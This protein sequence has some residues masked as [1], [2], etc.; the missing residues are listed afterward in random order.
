MPA[1]EIA[2]CHVPTLT[3]VAPVRAAF[4]AL[5][6]EI[7]PYGWAV[8]YERPMECS[9]LL[10]YELRGPREYGAVVEER[11]RVMLDAL[12]ASG[13]HRGPGAVIIEPVGS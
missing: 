10:H 1:G 7:A 8:A 11:V 3:D 4:S 5:C 13:D 2:S 12:R 9:G 6:A